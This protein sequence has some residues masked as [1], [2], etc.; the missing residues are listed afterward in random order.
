LRSPQPPVTIPHPRHLILIQIVARFSSRLS[1][2]TFRDGYNPRAARPNFGSWLGFIESCEALQTAEISARQ[3]AAS[4]LEML[5]VTPMT[6]SFKMV[7]LLAALNE[8]QLP[9]SIP[10]ADLVAAVR[11]YAGQHPRVGVDLGEALQTDAALKPHLE[12]NPI[13]A[14]TGTVGTGGERYFSYENEAFAT[15]FHVPSEH[16]ASF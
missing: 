7:V 9:G 4:F 13:N 8:D 10:I 12:R 15:T 1:L 5:E 11:R 14:W 16:R 2:Y 6:R 3:A